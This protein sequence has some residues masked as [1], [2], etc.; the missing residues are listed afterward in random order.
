ME[1]GKNTGMVFKWKLFYEPGMLR[2][3]LIWE[4]ATDENI[5]HHKR[6]NIYSRHQLPFTII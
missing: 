5:A 1:R 4:S 6:K 2:P 3:R